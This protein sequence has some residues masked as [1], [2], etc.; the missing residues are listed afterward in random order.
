MKNFGIGAA[1]PE[2]FYT[3]CCEVWLCITRM[4]EYS[5]F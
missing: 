5:K 2:I 1:T 3:E 4:P